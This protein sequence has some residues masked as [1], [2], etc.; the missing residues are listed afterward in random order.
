MSEF[1][2]F[3]N[4]HAPLHYSVKLS[5]ESIQY[6]DLLFDKKTVI[7]AVLKCIVIDKDWHVN[8]TYKGYNIPLSEWFRSVHDC[9]LTRT[10]MLEIIFASYIES[11]GSE[12]NTNLKQINAIQF[13]QP[14][15]Q[16]KYS[17]SSIRLSLL[18][19]YNS[20]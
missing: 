6:F 16:P 10:R 19:S 18:L 3:D 14:K 9:K 4:L 15:G 17:S 12:Q 13:Y 1:Q 11:K 5:I 8:L 2:F 20:C 7:P